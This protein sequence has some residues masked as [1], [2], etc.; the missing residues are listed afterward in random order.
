MWHGQSAEALAKSERAVDLNPIDPISHNRFGQILIVAGRPEE[1]LPHLLT[2]VRLNSHHPRIYI[3]RVTLARAYLDAHKYE[4]AAFQA[5]Q[6]VHRGGSFTD[7]DI[8]LASALGHLNRVEEAMSVLHNVKES[9]GLRIDDVTPG[10]FWQLYKDPGPN[11]HLLEGL[12]MAGLQ[13]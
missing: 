13:E 5:R 8:I 2:A 3:Y 11:E 9:R 12:R 4:E 1:A 7:G 10:P 6:A